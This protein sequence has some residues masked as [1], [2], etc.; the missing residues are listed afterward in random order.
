MPQATFDI[1][2]GLS[3]IAMAVQVE[4][5]IADEVCPLVNAE[6]PRFPYTRVETGSRLRIPDVRIGRTGRANQVEHESRDEI[7]E[8]EDY[9]LEDPVPERD[10]M[11]AMGVRHPVDPQE[12]ATEATTQLV[13]LAREKRVADL[14]FDRANYS[15]S[16]RTDVGNNMQWNATATSNPRRAIMAAKNRM[17]VRPNT[18]VVGQ[19][20]WIELAQHPRMVE[21]AVHSGAG[22]A[23]AEGMLTREQVA[24]VLEVDRVLVGEAWNNEAARGQDDDYERLWG[25]HAAL[26][27]ITRPVMT[28]KVVVPTF[29]FTGSW[30]RRQVGTYF[31]P[32]RG[33]LGTTTVRVFESCRELISWQGAGYLFENVI[34]TN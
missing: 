17:L 18:L 19:S 3:E 34:A 11:A 20:V 25:P 29:C 22:G 21:S 28:N 5:T 2:P 4:G 23:G 9:G 32:D 10:K 6:S 33:I 1:Q 27:R 7:V 24:A 31:A 15:E 16:L 12:L 13:V 26:L 14:I 30:I 8:V